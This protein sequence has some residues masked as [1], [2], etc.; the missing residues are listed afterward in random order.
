[1]Q[2]G[3]TMK[4]GML[5]H[6]A[7]LA[8]LLLLAACGKTPTPADPEPPAAGAATPPPAGA[9]APA[10]PN[11]TVV[12][13]DAV[14]PAGPQACMIAGEFQLLGQRIRSRDCVQVLDGG[15]EQ[16]L[17]RLCEGLAQGSAQMGGKA[18]EVTYMDACPSPSQGSCQGVFG[19]AFAGYYYERSAED[20]ASL[21]ASCAHGGGRWVAN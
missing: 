21:P 6:G 8:G 14:A 3:W 11:S 1:M 13:K 2:G 19:G 7:V 10:A 5:R 12:H 15:R 9:P 4:E 18:G 17:R 16:D 20:L